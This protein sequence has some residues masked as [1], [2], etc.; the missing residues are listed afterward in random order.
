MTLAPFDVVGLG[1]VLV[2]HL[3]VL[4]AHPEADTKT[5]VLADHLQVGGPVPTALAML[6]RLGRRCAFLGSWSDDAFGQLIQEDLD[7][8]QIDRR[9]VVQRRG[10]RTGFAHAWVCQQSA[11]RTVAHRRSEQP[12]TPEE[13]DCDLLSS[14][15]AL[16]LDGWPPEAALAAAQVAEAA[17]VPVVLDAGSPKP[18][19]SELLRHVD[20]LNAPRRFLREFLDLDDVR[21]GIEQLLSLGPRL[22]T[23]TSGS[24]GAALGTPETYCELPALEVQAT[25]TTGAGDVFT[26]ALIH[27]VLEAWPPNE[28]LRFAMVAAALKCERLGNRAALPDERAIRS[29]MQRHRKAKTH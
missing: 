19:M 12:I 7:R 16:H 1:T 18:G 29:A 24:E 27:A 6:R 23:V 2:D 13:L 11:Q 10:G 26:G 21:E 25:D 14:A 22:V 17:G 15:S 9:G 8:E 20:V 3:V 28:M 5:A 4:P